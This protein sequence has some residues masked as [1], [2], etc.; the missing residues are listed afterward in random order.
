MMFH[1]KEAFRHVRA[2]V[3]FE[4]INLNSKTATDSLINQTIL[5]LRRNGVGLNGI[6]D[7]DHTN[8]NSFSINIVLLQKLDLFANV[9]RCKTVNSVKTRHQDIDILII[10]ENTEGEYS[11][12]EVIKI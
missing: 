8:L 12:L 11:N 2:P 4:E 1:V 10:R 3:E 9:L 6:I 7:T 5:A